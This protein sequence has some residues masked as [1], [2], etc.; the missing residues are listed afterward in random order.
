MA[1]TVDAGMMDTLA[2]VDGLP[3]WLRRMGWHEA[4]SALG[5][6]DAA[7]DPVVGAVLQALREAWRARCEGQDLAG[8]YHVV[9]PLA[10]LAGIGT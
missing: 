8:L 2:P 4:A 6:D 3:E 9:R 1:L 7:A 5:S 10:V